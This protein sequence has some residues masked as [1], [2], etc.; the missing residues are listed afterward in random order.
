VYFVVQFQ[1]FPCI[2]KGSVTMM[3]SG[4]I[5]LLTGSILLQEWKR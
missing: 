1:L 2:Q 3:W 5:I 4:D